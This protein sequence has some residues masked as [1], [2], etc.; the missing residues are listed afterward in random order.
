MEN[1]RELARRRADAVMA[2]IALNIENDPQVNRTLA[3]GAAG[4]AP[5]SFYRWL[6]TP[7]KKLDV[8]AVS[9]VADFLHDEYG[10]PDFATIWRN[11]A[12]QIK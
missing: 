9:A 12:A 7:P 2:R 11:V 4:V 10:H 3:A 5:S 8:A 1:R 6:S